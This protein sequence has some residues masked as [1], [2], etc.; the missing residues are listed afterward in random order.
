MKTKNFVLIIV[1][2]FGGCLGRVTR[3]Q[4]KNSTPSVLPRP[5]FHFPGSVGRTYLESDPPQ[6]P[7]PV[8]APKGAPNVLLILLDDAGF[9]QFSTFGG[10][11]P[12]PTMDKLAAEGLRY[13]RFHTTALCSPTRAALITGRN[14]H[15]ASFAV[16]TET[17][18]GYDG[19]TCVLPKN[20]GTISEVLRQNGYMTAWIGK[21]HN[22][23]PW[24]TSQAG[25]FDRWANGLGFD[26]F[27]GFNAGDMNHWNPILYENH[28]LVPASGDPQYHLTTDIAN[29]AIQWVRQVKSIAPDRPFFLYVA[30]GATHAPHQAPKDWIAK[31]KG[32]FDGGWDKYREE[33]FERQKKLGVIPQSTKL[34]TRSEGLPAWESLNAD[35]KRLY[36]RMMEVFAAYGAHCDYE[37]GRVV[38][39]VKQLPDADNTMIIYIAGDNGSSAEGGIEGS[40]N[41]NLFFNGFPEKWQDNL[42]VIDEL[43]GPKHFNHFPSAWAHA[44]NTPF[45]WTKQVASHFGGTR[46]PLIISWPAKIKDKGGLRSQFIHTIDIVPTIY[47]VCGITA[48]LELN[49]VHQKPI[50]GVSFASSFSDAKVITR[51]T[52]YFELGVNRG[53][54]SDGW[55]ASALSFPP[56]QPN[57]EKFDVDKQKWELYNIDEDFSQANDLAAQ[58][59][60]KLRQMQD[61]WWVEASAYNVLPL[62][63]RAS[64]RLNAEAMGRPTL[65]GHRKTMTYYSGTIGLPDAASP[66]MT[67]KSWTIT[68]DIEV[69]A[70]G[71]GMIVTHGGLEGGYGLYLH[72]GKPVFVYNYLAIERSLFTSKEVLAKGKNKIVVDFAY[73][74]GGMGKGGKITMTANGKKIAEG[75]LEKTIPIQFSL[76]EGLDV[77]MDVGSAVDFS[78]KLPFAFT[79]M[80]ERVTV[81]LK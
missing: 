13:N 70:K 6:F 3:A 46:N 77:G 79:G 17:A 73:D 36:A 26:Y 1:I 16:I 30:P 72:D 60:E 29:H 76:G 81:E 20:C 37:M 59:P 74:G 10:G 69:P 65:M 38:D 2:F 39:A 41:E 25:P 47:E 63:W 11:V 4:E 12:S 52:Q 23:P 27:Y 54:Y 68:A 58:N 78:Y 40:L 51:K 67:N 56:W 22:T 9:G 80:V 33:T 44:M 75:R 48:P 31:F 42:K 21:N 66:N 53:I 7:K 50:E 35:Q 45:Q 15:S 5:D 8:E 24:E 62:D 61:L 14:H 18:T 34:T 55:M 19:Y 43:G 64:I 49:G 28:N 57:R 71:N 32:K